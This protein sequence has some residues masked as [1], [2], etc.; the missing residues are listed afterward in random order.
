MN[1]T[2]KSWIYIEE[3]QSS[4]KTVRMNNEIVNEKSNMKCL[5]VSTSHH[6][7]GAMCSFHVNV[8]M[9]VCFH[10][11]KWQ[12][13]GVISANAL[14]G[15]LYVLYIHA[16]CHAREVWVWKEKNGMEKCLHTATRYAILRNCDGRKRYII[17]SFSLF[18]WMNVALAF[19]SF[20]IANHCFAI[21]QFEFAFR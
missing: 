6:I 21:N 14:T 19:H 8:R 9:P 2:Y 11:R 10:Y 17:I 16:Y 12:R 5:E 15:L 13:F 7:V 3:K 20:R 18:C 1:H 4:P